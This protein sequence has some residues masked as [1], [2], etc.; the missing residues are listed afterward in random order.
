[1]EAEETKLGKREYHGGHRVQGVW[2]IAEI[3]RNAKKNLINC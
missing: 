1:M 3:E 2:V